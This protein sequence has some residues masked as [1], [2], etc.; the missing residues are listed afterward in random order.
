MF[1]NS[2]EVMERNYKKIHSMYS[3][4]YSFEEMYRECGDME[5]WGVISVVQTIEGRIRQRQGE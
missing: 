1:R 3:K 5:R 4:G 2:K